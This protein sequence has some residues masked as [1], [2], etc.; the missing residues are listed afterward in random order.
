MKTL[1]L[2]AIWLIAICVLLM[3][4][5]ASAE[6]IPGGI[7]LGLTGLILLPPIGTRLPK[8]LKF[9]KAKTALVI[10]NTAFCF[11]GLYL[12]HL[13][14]LE[15]N[16]EFFAQNKQY[17]LSQIN[18]YI[19]Q[20]EF[21]SASVE[22]V[23]Y[24]EVDDPDLELLKKRMEREKRDVQIRNEALADKQNYEDDRL[25]KIKNQFSSWNGEHT[26]LVD[27]I[28]SDL[29]DP[30]SFEHVESLYLDLHD[31][32]LVEVTYRAN[33]MY[34]AKVKESIAARFTID[35]DFIRLDTL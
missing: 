33:N 31:Y 8:L 16:K 12:L 10:A 5:G 1:K 22:F 3:A 35:G 11:I 20:E 2:I 28:K 34:G 19:D 9:K 13:E 14:Q 15:A 26:K 21:E 30:S 24:S 25:E 18:D 27:I 32:V 29:H 17:V 7:F 23:K 4:L 6:T